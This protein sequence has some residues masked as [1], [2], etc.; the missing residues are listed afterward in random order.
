MIRTQQKRVPWRWPVYLGVLAAGIAF[1]NGNV[2]APLTLTV[3]KFVD[4]PWLIV[5]ITSV[6]QAFSML[7]APYASW[8]AD[9]IWTRFGRRKPFMM[10]GWVLMAVGLAIVPFAPNV[11]ILMLAIIIWQ[12]SFDFG[13]VGVW[14]PLC[15]EVVP[16]PQRG[17]AQVIRKFI[18]IPISLFFNWV[19]IRQFEEHYSLSPGTWLEKVPWL[20]RLV[21]DGWTI[22]FTGEHVIYLSGV[23][24]LGVI[25]TMLIFG[26]KETRPDKAV[27]GERFALGRFFL[28]LFG[29]RQW[30]MIYLLIFCVACMTAGLAA[31]GTLLIKEQFHYDMKD[32]GMMTTISIIL[33]V[34]I[35]L[36]LAALVV[37]RF[38]R[39]R[40][41]QVG[42]LLSTIHPIAFWL[43]VKYLAPN[44]IPAIPWIIFFTMFNAV[45]DGTAS[46]ALEP[47]IFDLIPRS[48]MGTV[49]SGFLLIRGM[50]GIGITNGV[51][52]WVTGHAWLWGLPSVADKEG[53]LMQTYDYMSGY[54][55]V[56]A[57]GVAGCL[58]AW[59]FG[60]ELRSG[61]II[62]Y[63]KLEDE[64]HPA[65][66]P[67]GQVA[68]APAGQADTAPS[69][70]RPA[71]KA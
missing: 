64:A 2:G 50:L 48:H 70:D 44:H 31:L 56:F 37:D 13:Y 9:R 6:N 46:I 4:K 63:G 26:L 24:A 11:W 30:R 15:F 47:L 14:T 57:L 65:T 71:E 36:P 18:G 8:K 40:I 7:V 59:Y 62:Q 66:M 43:F 32:L 28:S 33:E 60:R 1:A 49:N 42:L 22:Q 55:Y 21:R 3:K 19:L 38:N 53:K 23:A 52:F 61:R 68:P 5:M 10:L 54:L 20:S 58:V 16:S 69:P 27:T 34:S 45:V 17:R 39:F 35:I 67:A 51:G 41:F 25:L 12:V 29:N